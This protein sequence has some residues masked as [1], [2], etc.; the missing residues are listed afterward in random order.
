MKTFRF[1]KSYEKV[2]FTTVEAETLE[3]AKELAN[4]YDWTEDDEQYLV[5][6]S[7]K[8]VESSGDI[9]DD[10]DALNEADEIITYNAYSHD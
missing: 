8:V 9:W 7:Y 5:R 6:E 10:D 3:Q 2:Y 1:I 4:D